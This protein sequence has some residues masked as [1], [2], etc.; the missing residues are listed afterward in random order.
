MESLRILPYTIGGQAV[1]GRNTAQSNGQ[2]SFCDAVKWSSSKND[3]QDFLTPV[4]ALHNNGVNGSVIPLYMNVTKG[5]QPH[6]SNRQGYCR[7]TSSLDRGLG[8]RLYVWF[9]QMVVVIETLCV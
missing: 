5:L 8:S 1:N 3:G 9:A 6:S 2:E 4:A 7:D